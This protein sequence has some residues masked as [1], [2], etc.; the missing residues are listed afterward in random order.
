[1]TVVRCHNVVKHA[2]TKAPL[3]FKEPMQVT[4]AITCKLE[5]KF[6]LMTAVS[7]VPDVSGYKMTVSTRHLFSLKALKA[8]F[9]R[10][11]LASKPLKDAFYA[12]LVCEINYFT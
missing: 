2:Q 6:S 1:M 11:K 5:Q 3:S 7:D 8:H 12:M 9:C 10:Q 4:A